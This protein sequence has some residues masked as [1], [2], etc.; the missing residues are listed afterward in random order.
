MAK[1]KINIYDPT[2]DAFFEASYE[3]AEKFAKSA[4]D[5]KEKLRKIKE[6]KGEK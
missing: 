4:D 5:V 3:V 1:E 2:R 6:I